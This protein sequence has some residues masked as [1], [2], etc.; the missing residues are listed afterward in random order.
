MPGASILLKLCTIS[1]VP[2]GRHD[3]RD[4][5]Y[6]PPPEAVLDLK[7]MLA[8]KAVLGWRP[9]RCFAAFLGLLALLPVASARGAEL[10]F[11][12]P[13]REAI[14]GPVELHLEVRADE[15]VEAV[16]FILDGHVVGRVE[17]P[18][19]RLLVDVGQENREHLIEA[20]ALSAGRELARV[21]L[22]TPAITVDEVVDLDLQQLY[23]TVSA[24]GKR[25]LGLEKEQFRLA[26]RGRE[27]EIITFETGN[28]PFTAILLF[29][30]SGSMQGEGLRL[31]LKGARTFTQNMQ[32][33]DEASIMTFADRLLAQTPFSQHTSSLV[34]PLL[35]AE[36]RDGTAV[37]DHLYL[38]LLRLE[39][40]QGRRV[41][42]L[43]SDGW[44]LHS[45]LT[46]KQ[47]ER[48]ARLSQATIYWLRPAERP[49][50]GMIY[51]P[52][53]SAWRNFNDSTKG[54]GKLERIVRRSGGRIETLK[55]AG[56]VETR[57]QEILRELR[58]QYALGY[59]PDPTL[60]DGS[61]R[62]VKVRLLAQGM[63]ARTRDGYVD[64]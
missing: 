45:V 63:K 16:E 56:Q 57:L 35:A 6:H 52:P 20:R 40:R 28:L 12:A 14:F 54:R 3:V 26:D 39:Q 37:L 5:M 22:L 61:W 11:L 44:D 17:T 50:P 48:M 36:A 53:L 4:M 15:R 27:Q 1:Y 8:T 34:A 30:A 9:R 43:L 41:V 32:Q 46:H 38:A 33:L 42:I 2:K 29:D 47:L 19:Y 62:E 10:R 64:R 60:N 49:P 7:T 18:P 21:E 55:N 59:Y 31:A 51:F 58:E 13:A 24:K 25:V 23:V